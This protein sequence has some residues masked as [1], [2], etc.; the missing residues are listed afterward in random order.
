MSDEIQ[1]SQHGL[2]KTKIKITKD[3]LKIE[4]AWMA[5]TLFFQMPVTFP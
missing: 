2:L 3:F 5:Q 4:S 1:S